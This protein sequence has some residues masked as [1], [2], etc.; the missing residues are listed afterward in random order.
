[1]DG[2][3]FWCLWQCYQRAPPTEG[4]DLCVLTGA[5]PSATPRGHDSDEDLEDSWL[6]MGIA[7]DEEDAAD[8]QPRPPVV[9]IM[10][11]VD[12]GKTSLLDAIRN[13]RVTAG[14][15]GG[16]TQAVSAY[17]ANTADGA[18]ITFI[19]TPGHA[20][21]TDMRERGANTADMSEHRLSCPFSFARDEAQPFVVLVIIV[22][23]P[24]QSS[25]WWPRTTASSSRPLTASRA[26]GR[27]GCRCWWR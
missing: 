19:D 10:G 4:L 12:H 14:E 9:T 26:P 23:L 2:A 20:A 8:L 15:A 27:L 13:T 11:H 21:F 25:L 17:Q 16:I 3:C 22:T 5:L 1:M 6:E 24:R 7:M 18:T